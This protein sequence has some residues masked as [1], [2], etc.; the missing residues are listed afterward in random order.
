MA[1]H[2]RIVAHGLLC[3]ESQGNSVVLIVRQ[4]RTHG[5][6]SIWVIVPGLGG[7]QKSVY[8]CLGSF[9]KGEKNT[10]SKFSQFPGQ[11]R[12]NLVLCFVFFGGFLCS[13]NRVLLKTLF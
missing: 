3:K 4:K 9:L 11:S 10:Q 13:Q 7:W 12:E 5:H 6:K 1:V 2:V 8:G